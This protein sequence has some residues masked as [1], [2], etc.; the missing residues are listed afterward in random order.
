MLDKLGYR[1]F[2]HDKNFI[3][4]QI[5]IRR[6]HAVHPPKHPEFVEGAQADGK[7]TVLPIKKFPALFKNGTGIFLS[8]EKVIFLSFLT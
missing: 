7:S 8:W 6:D 2:V 5:A 3:R 1:S 4:L